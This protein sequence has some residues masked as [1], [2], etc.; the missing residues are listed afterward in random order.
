MT[1]AAAV[2][3]RFIPA[4]LP[5]MRKFTMSPAMPLSSAIRRGNRFRSIRAPAADTFDGSF[6]F[7][8]IMFQSS[9]GGDGGNWSVDYPR[10]DVNL[11]IRAAE[12]T[13]ARQQGPLGEVRTPGRHG[14]FG[15]V[16]SFLIILLVVVSQGHEAEER[17][18][19]RVLGIE[20]QASQQSTGA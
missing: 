14:Q 7:C 5:R 10:A 18:G 3:T 19:L 12:L 6:N 17:P 20:P 2:Y 1:H 13:K 11:S 9:R 8:R 4:S 15:V 16:Q